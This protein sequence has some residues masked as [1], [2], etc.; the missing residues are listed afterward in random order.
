[1]A[2]PTPNIL[3]DL[4]TGESPILLAD[5]R[6]EPFMPR[7][8]GKKLDKSVPFRWASRGTAGVRLESITTPTGKATTRS[9]VLRFFVAL[10]KNNNPTVPAPTL[11]SRRAAVSRAH[12]ELAAAGI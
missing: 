3:D 5:L 12:A 2:D 10:S 11:R 1:M 9:A 7:K 8:A 6:N 4:S